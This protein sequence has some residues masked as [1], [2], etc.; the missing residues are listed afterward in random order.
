MIDV[1]D[2]AVRLV[3][4]AAEQATGIFNASGKPLPFPAHI[5]ITQSVI[6]H[7]GSVIAAPE[8]WLLEQGVNEWSGERS[9]PFWLVD[10]DCYARNLL[11]NLATSSGLASTLRQ[12]QNCWIPALNPPTILGPTV[13]P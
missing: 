12:K 4:L 7:L 3:H 2:L 11:W 10:R 13:N 8:Q 6:G 5:R 1:R 9:W